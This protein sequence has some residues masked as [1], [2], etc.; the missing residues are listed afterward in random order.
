MRSVFAQRNMSAQFTARVLDWIY[1]ASTVSRKTYSEVDAAFAAA[2]S[3]RAVARARRSTSSL[4]LG[5][6][7]F[8]L[9]GSVL[10]GGGL[11]LG[12]SLFSFSADRRFLGGRALSSDARG[13]DDRLPPLSID[14]EMCCASTRF[15]L[16]PRTYL[17]AYVKPVVLFSEPSRMGP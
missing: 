17:T 7:G 6:A 11:F 14:L 13:D 8:F 5:G 9:G 10:G 15:S 2:A 3:W 4:G 12:G 1:E 16:P